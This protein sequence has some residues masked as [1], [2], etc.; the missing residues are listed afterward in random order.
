MLIE[1]HLQPRE[2]ST[3]PANM[4]AALFSGPNTEGSGQHI[5]VNAAKGEELR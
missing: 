4:F 1:F 2:I 3:T 5:A